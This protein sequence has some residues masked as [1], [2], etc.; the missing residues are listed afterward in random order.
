MPVQVG[1]KTCRLDEPAFGRIAY[2]VMGCVF[3]IH[4]EF[5]RYFDEKIYARELG[6]RYPGTESEVPIEVSFESFHKL[7]LLDALVGG[8]AAFKFKTVEALTAGHRSQFL[9]YLL[10]ADLP[11]GKLVNMKTEQ[12][13]HEFVNTTLRPSDRTKFAVTDQGW[14]EIGDK[15]M[16][17]WCVAFLRD[18]GASLDISLYEE[19]LTH[20]LGGEEQVV[21]EVEVI[22]GGK[23]LGPQKFR[24]VTPG[25]AFKVTAMSDP[26]PFVVHARRLLDHTSLKALQWINVTRNEVSF[27]TIR[28]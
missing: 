16:R 15:P 19:A 22:S 1:A 21:Q 28:K 23:I 24:L 12:V 25:V 27:R 3:D 5:G 18:V 9:H 14:Q 10:L 13:Q 17:E 11:H 4:K 8:G 2:D 6:R 26:D 7:Y 20:L